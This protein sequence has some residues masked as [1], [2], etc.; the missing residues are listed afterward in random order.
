[1]LHIWW[2]VFLLPALM[3]LAGLLGRFLPRRRGLYP[4]PLPPERQR[5]AD[6]LL[7]KQLLRL[8]PALAVLAYMIMQSLRLTPEHTQ[9]VIAYIVSFSEVFTLIS[10]INSI[11]QALQE[12]F[13]DAPAERIITETASAKVNLL[14][15]VSAPRPD[16]FHELISVMQTVGLCDQLTLRATEGGIE[17]TCDRDDLLADDSN[18]CNKAAV[19]FF[20]HTG[21]TGAGVSIELKKVI[22]M[23]AGLGGGSSDA[24][25]VLRGL[26]RLYAPDLSDAELE[27]MAAE[28]GSDVPFCVRGGTTLARG[29]GEV[30]ETLPA[31]PACWF[32]IVKPAFACCTAEMYGLI[33]KY[34]CYDDGEALSAAMIRALE[35]GDLRGVCATLDN[36]F[37][38]TLPQDNV[39][40]AIRRRLRELGALGALLCGSGSAVF[41]VFDREEEARVAAAAL[42]GTYPE[43]FCA[44][45]E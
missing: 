14:L 38:R 45:A 17:L 8:G 24:A 6:V 22:P 3:V 5:F 20:T 28:L 40:Y 26:R 42:R 33:D 37:E 30:L 15:A 10:I 44:S 34:R 36:T 9:R 31:L 7:L 16:G 12:R 29:R 1:M 23:Q 32:V 21:I 43:T 27:N 25:A 35:Q 13:G 41:G 11:E 18:L 2:S 39:V 4:R 19:K